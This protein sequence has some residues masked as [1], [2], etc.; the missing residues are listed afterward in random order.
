MDLILAYPKG[1]Q[2]SDGRKARCKPPQ[3]EQHAVTV[4]KKWRLTDQNRRRQVDCRL[5]LQGFRPP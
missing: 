2:A 4:G 1:G 5:C 3:R